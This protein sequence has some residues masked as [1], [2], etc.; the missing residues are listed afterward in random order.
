[1]TANARAFRGE[2]VIAA[3]FMPFV[4]EYVLCIT[5]R[6]NTWGQRCK[7]KGSGCM[8]L[9]S[10]SDVDS[11]PDTPAMQMSAVAYLHTCL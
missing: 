5:L 8:F 11:R 2:I 4:T 9:D 1:M 3:A 7:I 6:Y 10:N